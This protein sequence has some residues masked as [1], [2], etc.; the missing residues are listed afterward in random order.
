[1]EKGCILPDN[2]IKEISQEGNLVLRSLSRFCACTEKELIDVLKMRNEDPTDDAILPYGKK[3][4][5]NVY[6]YIKSWKQVGKKKRLISAPKESLKKI[7]EGIKTRLSY[8]PIS[9]A[10]TA[11]RIGDSPQKN[12]DLHRYNPYLIT[13]DIKNAYPSINT[14]RVYKCLE[15]SLMKPLSI[16]CPLLQTPEEKR[17]FVRAIT[18]LCVSE[19]QLP[20]GASTSNVIQNIVMSKFDAKIEKK[21]PELT[22]SHI[23]YS[24]YADDIA[25]SFPHFSTM[26]V[27]KEKMENY[28][29]DI[30]GQE[31]Q[32]REE[33]EHIIEKFSKEKFI[34][35]DRFEL[36]YLQKQIKE[37]R[38][39]LQQSSLDPEERCIYI[40]IIDG[41]KKSIRYTDWRILDVSDE[42]IDIIGNEG[43]KIN[44]KK[45]KIRTPQ[46]NDDR[47]INGMT[48]DHTGKRGID[49]KKRSQYMRLLKDLI[50][51]SLDDMESKNA[52]YYARKFKFSQKKD[53]KER[54]ATIID[55]IKG[56]HGYIS[57]IYGVDES[58][59]SN[60]PRDLREACEKAKKKRENYQSR[61]M[62]IDLLEEKKVG[63][64]GSKRP[65][66][67]DIPF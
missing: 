46:G 13:I 6:G 4:K 16:W 8:I 37:L 5:K 7:Q 42:I 27:L 44:H 26:D 32:G 22:G 2:I 40:G 11:G 29:A 12:A 57:T 35:T 24:R 50:D 14:N 59:K 45:F 63:V 19:D 53:E 28:L 66:G 3:S 67:D 9:F 23:I 47:V 39:F 1:M 60:I 20:Q 15:G 41:Y 10:S 51:L 55:T 34:L 61:K 30:R 52:P 65:S 31:M 62:E 43:R 36:T 56:T 33:I 54:I 38:K 17:L 49:K 21:L 64:S 25:V 58:G 48:F 18:H